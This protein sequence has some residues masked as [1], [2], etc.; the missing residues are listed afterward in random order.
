MSSS[1]RYVLTQLLVSASALSAAAGI[2][3]VSDEAQLVQA[4]DNAMPGDEIVLAPG[5]YEVDQVLRCDNPGTAAEPIVVRS[6]ELGE[7]RIRFDTVEGFKVSAPHWHFENLD[8]RGVCA[9]HSVCE[10]AFHIVREADFTIVRH[11]R[12]WDFNA[13]IKGNGEDPGGGIVF[14]DDVIVEDSEFFNA[15]V[16]NTGN[17]VTP[18]DVVGGRRWIVRRN[19]IYDFAKGGG[20]GISYAAF[21]KGNS[22]DGLFE[23]NL[24]LCEVNHSDGIRLGL[25][26]GGGGSGPDPICEDGT[27]TPE[28]QRGVMRNNLI[29]N[30]PDDVGIYLNEAQETKIFNNTLYNTVGIDVRFVASTADI[31]NNLLSGR[32]QNRNGGTSTSSTNLTD[33]PLES[34]RSWFEDPDAADFSLLDGAAFVDLGEPLAEVTDDFC[35][36]ERD[37]GVPDIGPVEYDGDG[38]CDTT[39]GGGGSGSEI[40]GDGFESGDTSAWSSSTR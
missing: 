17:P 6:Q 2:V 28:H 22:R 7:A 33:V 14:P 4:I 18:I 23:R 5:L 21:L 9:S 39:V 10:H 35:G 15:T 25:S 8:V 38:P 31:R 1:K 16:R 40:F 36:N 27:C 24:V 34:F 12:L 30:C 19:T 29:V 3:N 11:C 37:D 13:Q 20:N 26:F 32:I